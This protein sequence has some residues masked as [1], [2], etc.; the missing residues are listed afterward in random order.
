MTDETEKRPG[1]QQYIDAAQDLYASDILQVDQDAVLSHTDEG[2]W[3]QAWVVIGDDRAAGYADRPRLVPERGS[4]PKPE[5]T[6]DVARLRATVI[7]LADFIE[8]VSED[9]PQRTAKFFKCR[10]LWRTTLHE[11]PEPERPAVVVI[12]DGGV[13]FTHAPNNVEVYEIDCDNIKE[14]DAAVELPDVPAMRALMT[15]SGYADDGRFF[16]WVKP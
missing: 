15:G 1:D 5:Q 2:A 9:D 6:G 13:A 10:E 3:V 7:A 16:T 8:N 14:G 4:A 11:T 12:V